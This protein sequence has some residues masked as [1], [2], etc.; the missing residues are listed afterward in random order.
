MFKVTLV[1]VERD[2]IR[3]QIKRP[4]PCK[5]STMTPLVINYVINSIDLTACEMKNTRKNSKPRILMK[6]TIASV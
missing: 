2:T 4:E 6:I 5:L 3:L 1:L